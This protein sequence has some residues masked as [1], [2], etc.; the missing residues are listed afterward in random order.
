MAD[1]LQIEKDSDAKGTNTHSSID[2]AMP[3]VVKLMINHYHF[4]SVN[5]LLRK[6]PSGTDASL[7][8]AG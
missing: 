2:K 3:M 8:F 7:R 5:K 1:Y 6:S 4:F